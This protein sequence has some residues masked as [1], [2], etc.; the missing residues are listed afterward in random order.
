VNPTE[1]SSELKHRADQRVVV[2]HQRLSHPFSTL[3]S[4]SN[5]L[6]WTVDETRINPEKP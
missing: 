6:S 4:T 2:G 1:R 3:I 5:R